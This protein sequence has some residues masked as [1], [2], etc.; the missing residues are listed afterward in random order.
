[1]L[2]ARRLDLP[3]DDMVAD[4]DEIRMLNEQYMA[5]RYPNFRA[6]IGMS[7]EDYTEE[8]AERCIKLAEE[9]FRRVE[10]WL[11]ARGLI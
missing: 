10:G 4:P 11:S 5:P 3:V 2:R 1:M 9:I 7:I 6:E 8:L